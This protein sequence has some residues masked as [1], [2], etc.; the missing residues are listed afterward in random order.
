MNVTTRATEP[1]GSTTTGR[2]QKRHIKRPANGVDVAEEVE[3]ISFADHP[4]VEVSNEDFLV[5]IFHE[6]QAGERPMTVTIAGTIDAGT[7]W[8]DADS[9]EPGY[10]SSI[11]KRDRNQYFTL[12]TFKP[13][14]ATGAY[15]RR[16]GQFSRAFG[17]MIDD[18]G[19][20]DA[21]LS[22]FDACP[23]SYLV[24]TSPGNY[25]G[26]YLF[27]EPVADVRQVEALVEALVLATGSDPGASG[28]AARLGRLPVGIN[29][30]YAPPATVKLIKFD[31][32][33]R[34]SIGE[35]VTRLELEDFAP[36]SHPDD[37]EAIYVPKPPENA[38]LVALREAGL[39]KTASGDGKHDISCPWLAEHTDQIDHGSC[40]F[41]PSLAFGLGGFKCLHGSCANRHIRDLLDHLHLTAAQA[42][43]KSII[44]VRP[45]EMDAITDAAEQELATLGTHFDV[46]GLIATV[47][48]RSETGEHRTVPTSINAVTRALSRAVSWVRYDGRSKAMIRIDPPPRHVGLLHEAD[49]Y[50]HLASLHGI[51]RQPYLGPDDKLVMTPGF[52][53]QTGMLGVFDADEFSVPENPTH[54]DAERA[55]D[56]LVELLDEFDFT[57]EVDGAAAVLALLTAA[58]RASLPAA[59]MFLVRAPLHGAGKSYLCSLIAS[60]ATPA[61]PMKLPFPTTEEEAS[62]V[63]LAAFL[64]KPAVVEFD[65]LVTD[66]IPF[67]TL[68]TALSA[69]QISGRILGFS[70]TA[71]VSTCSLMLSSGN[72]VGPVRDMARRTVTI[73]IDPQHEMPALR[74]FQHDPLA[75][76]QADRGRYVSAALTVVRAYLAAGAPEQ[77]QLQP[78]AGYETWT[79]TARSALAWL[80]PDL[81]DAIAGTIEHMRDDPDRAQLG[82]VL[83]GWHKKW[84][85][86]PVK[87]RQLTEYVEGIGESDF[88]DAIREIAAQERTSPAGG[89]LLNRR[90]LGKWLS[91]HARRIVNGLQLEKV[92]GKR[93]DGVER[94][95]VLGEPTTPDDDESQT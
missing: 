49:H 52:D 7:K 40:Y 63:L 48:V 53:P 83:I 69:P 17:V 8:P 42:R 21:P 2:R 25:Q 35:I 95:H 68:S 20:P 80:W 15:N 89:V 94:W 85:D 29:G 46:G 78:L 81:P 3:G 9:W 32:A 1:R 86:K 66:L 50:G 5:A 67:K 91:R 88:A 71:T 24:E 37:E 75:L 64:E 27:S 4:G 22:R 26:G 62:K 72:N 59:P 61:L 57:T 43:H 54:E 18:L 70:K 38:V 10:R 36:H 51:A 6:L 33:L 41:E 39:Y 73:N 47:Q 77:A 28:P 16:K 19:T 55:G 12:S 23:L 13:D 84:A 34:Y 87:V 30:K 76:V 44:S 90:V 14:A 60:F 11:D 93:L 56:V 92:K 58:V 45:G 79:R 31:P 65:N 74:H 82:R